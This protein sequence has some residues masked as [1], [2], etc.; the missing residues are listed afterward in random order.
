MHKCYI[1]LYEMTSISTITVVTHGGGSI[2]GFLTAVTGRV[3]KL[4]T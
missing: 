2:V 3:A 1:R 4:E